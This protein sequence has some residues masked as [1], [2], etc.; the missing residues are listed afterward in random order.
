MDVRHRITA[1]TKHQTS[2]ILAVAEALSSR[3]PLDEPGYSAG[4][5]RLVEVV[6][7]CGA[8]DHE[9]VDRAIREVIDAYQCAAIQEATR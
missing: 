3:P 1:T 9:T 2:P 8:D 5:S 6:E 7:R 4:L